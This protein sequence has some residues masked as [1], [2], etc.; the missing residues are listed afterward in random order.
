MMPSKFDRLQ[1]VVAR[2]G[3]ISPIDPAEAQ[4]FFSPALGM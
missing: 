4:N 1:T 3:E 2:I